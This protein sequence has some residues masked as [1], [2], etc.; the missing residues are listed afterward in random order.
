M[1][2]HESNLST[3]PIPISLKKVILSKYRSNLYN[4]VKSF[5]PLMLGP[6]ESKSFFFRTSDCESMMNT[7]FMT[8]R[9]LLS[10]LQ[11]C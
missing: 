11:E 5:V 9:I 4:T 6:I 7:L 10:F 3:L 1:C 8:G 2:S